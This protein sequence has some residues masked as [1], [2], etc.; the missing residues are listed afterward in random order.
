LVGSKHSRIVVFFQIPF[1]FTCTFYR[2]IGDE[3]YSKGGNTMAGTTN[4]KIEPF[5]EHK[6]PEILTRWFTEHKLLVTIVSALT[7]LVGFIVDKALDEPVKDLM[8]SM[9]VAEQAANHASESVGMFQQLTGITSDLSLVKTKMVDEKPVD[10]KAIQLAKLQAERFQVLTLIGG[11][12]AALHVQ[13][14]ILPR[15]LRDEE[16]SFENDYQ[17]LLFASGSAADQAS[18][19]KLTYWSGALTAM[20]DRSRMLEGKAIQGLESLRE[21]S[22]LNHHIYLS[23]TYFCFILGWSVGLV[24]NVAG[25]QSV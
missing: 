4:G 12:I 20:A 2:F 7:V 23:L 11:N 19:Y 14:D 13:K 18:V 16:A 3:A 15:P 6:S 5:H 9:T 1:S 24:S 22:G 8:N 25:E 17:K 21:R 10:S